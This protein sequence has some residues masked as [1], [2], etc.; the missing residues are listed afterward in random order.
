MDN[1]AVIKE[2]RFVFK[3]SNINTRLGYT[4]TYQV[5]TCQCFQVYPSSRYGTQAGR[6]I[7]T[8]KGYWTNVY[9]TLIIL[10]HNRPF[11]GASPDFSSRIIRNSK[12]P[13]QSKNPHIKTSFS[14]KNK[15][16]HF[17]YNIF[18]FPAIHPAIASHSPFPA[19]RKEK[20]RE[21]RLNQ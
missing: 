20:S 8:L 6:D 1:C 11:N 18:S 4:H 13:F 10:V 21:S 3:I 16:R 17:S 2:M 9:S 5:Q 14:T 19:I 15:T 7:N 12:I